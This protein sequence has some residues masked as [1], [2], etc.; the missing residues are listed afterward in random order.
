MNVTDVTVESYIG[1]GSNQGN[2]ISIIK[3]SI[4]DLFLIFGSHS[5]NS[6]IYMSAPIQADG[7]NFINAVVKIFTEKSPLN[8]LKILQNLEKKYGRQRMY[9]NSPRTL[10]LDILLYG[11]KLIHSK[12]LAIPHP[13]MIERAFVLKPITDI[14]PD[15]EIPYYGKAQEL[16]N[17]ITDQYIKEIDE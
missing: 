6:K 11:N 4:S 7:P 16:L 14:D 10:D 12:V 13:R 15:I 2:S 1:L 9:K 5:I 8:L 17:N 3:R